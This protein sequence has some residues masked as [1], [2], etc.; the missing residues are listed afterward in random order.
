M[1]LAE[2]GLLITGFFKFA[3]KLIPLIRLLMKSSAE[4]QAQIL[5]RIAKEEVT[6][7]ETGRPQWD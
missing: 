4:Q 3:D 2:I 5:A 6:F 1:G 7:E